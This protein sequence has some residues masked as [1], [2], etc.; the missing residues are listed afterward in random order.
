M[1]ANNVLAVLGGTLMGLANAAASY[2]ILILGRFLIGA[3]S[4]TT[5][6]M[7]LLWASV[8]LNRWAS[9]WEYAAILGSLFFL[10]PRANIR[11]G[12]HVCGRNRPHSSSGCLGNTEPTGHR[13]WHSGCPGKRTWPC[14]E[15]GGGVGVDVHIWAGRRSKSLFSFLSFP[16]GVGLG[17][18]AG[19]SCPVATAS[20]SHGAP[21][22]PAADSVALLS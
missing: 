5:G 17:L 16:A 18:Y 11:V 10:L 9:I 13:H 19:H 20:G 1:L 4:G 21:C 12:A 2:E 14:G 15:L 8:L 6:A 3:Y 22:S 7:G